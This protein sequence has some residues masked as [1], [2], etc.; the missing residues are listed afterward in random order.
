MKNKFGENTTTLWTDKKRILGMPISFTR[1]SLVE[2]PEWTKVFVKSGFLS[3]TIDEINLYRIYDIKVYQ[4]LGQ[5][6]FGVGTITLYSNDITHPQTEIINVKKPY[7]VRNM[8]A[9]RIEEARDAKGVR[10]GEVY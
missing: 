3:T 10:I 1:Y 2:N 6:M 5:K 8:L 9:E 7:D 4:S